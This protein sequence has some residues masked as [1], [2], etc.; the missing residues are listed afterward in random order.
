[1]G[2]AEEVSDG[3][4]VGDCGRDTGY[5]IGKEEVTEAHPTKWRYEY[6]IY[7]IAQLVPSRPIPTLNVGLEAV[8]NEQNKESK[9]EP[10]WILNV[11]DVVDLGEG[12]CKAHYLE[13]EYCHTYFI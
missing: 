9:K 6:L 4:D 11:S 10:E 8:Y 1:M 5:Y 2:G 13:K 3:E 12:E 7:S